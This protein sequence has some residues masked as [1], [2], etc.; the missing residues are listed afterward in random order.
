MVTSV[1]PELT[2]QGE[3]LNI[4]GE[5]LKAFLLA[6]ESSY[7]SRVYLLDIFLAS[8]ISKGLAQCHW[9]YSPPAIL[10]F[11]VVFIPGQSLWEFYDIA[12][13]IVS[14]V[15]SIFW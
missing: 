2:G 4:P 13:R 1:E 12:S 14:H 11:I 7:R 5:C 9:H 15:A 3:G 10:I 8:N 6:K